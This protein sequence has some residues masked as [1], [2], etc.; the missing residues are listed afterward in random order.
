S[1]VE[2]DAPFNTLAPLAGKVKKSPHTRRMK[3]R[4]PM[5]MRK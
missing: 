4:L 5:V 3:R 1:T 2:K